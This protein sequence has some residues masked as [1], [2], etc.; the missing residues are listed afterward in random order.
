MSVRVRVDREEI[1]LPDGAT[2][3]DLL[4]VLKRDPAAVATAIN[5]EFV[6]RSAR[7]KREL[8]DGDRVLLFEPIAGG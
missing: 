8:H 7:E 4:R 3:A 1:E 2:A 5:G 6:A